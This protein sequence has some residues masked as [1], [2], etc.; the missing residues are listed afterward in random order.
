VSGGA[1]VCIMPAATRQGNLKAIMI[2]SLLLA[3]NLPLTLTQNYQGIRI[4]ITVLLIFAI[5]DRFYRGDHLLEYLYHLMLCSNRTQGA[6]D[7]KINRHPKQ[8]DELGNKPDRSV[9]I[10]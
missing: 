3:T 7:D 6:L 10:D 9:V 8:K 1:I 4:L 5:V 2:Q